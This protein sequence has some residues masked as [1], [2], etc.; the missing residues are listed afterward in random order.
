[1]CHAIMRVFMSVGVRVLVL[2]GMIVF[3]LAFHSISSQDSMPR[4]SEEH[5]FF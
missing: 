5:T 4:H 3:V 2:V 1:M